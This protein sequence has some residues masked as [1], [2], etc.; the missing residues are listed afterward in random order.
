VDR[1]RYLGE[2]AERYL[3]TVGADAGRHLLA[4]AAL[5]AFGLVWR[6]AAPRL[7]S[8][9]SSRRNWLWWLVA[10]IAVGLALALDRASLFDDAFISFRYA[11]NW[12]DGHGLVFNPGEPVE[13]YTNFLWVVVV[14]AVAAVTGIELPAVGLA[15]SLV[16]FA[17][18]LVVV[19]R[20]ARQLTPTAPVP[21]ATCLLAVQYTFTSFGTTGMETGA[22]SLLV[23]L[24]AL[25]LVSGGGP[26]KAALAGLALVLAAL[27]RPDHAIFYG[28]GGIA[29]VAVAAPANWWRRPGEVARRIAP[30]ALAYA[31][32]L[33]LYAVY[34][35]WKLSFYGSM[36]PNTYFAKS[37]DTP[38]WDQGLLYAAMFFLDSHFWILAI[39]FAVWLASRSPNEGT[40]R[41]RV[42]AGL[43]VPLYTLYVIRVGGDFMHGRFFVS[44]MPLLAL[45]AEQLVWMWR[46]R[47]PGRS[48]QL[49]ALLAF[50]IGGGAFFDGSE[51][52]WYVVDERRYYPL[53]QL[54]PPVVDHA[55]YRAGI[56]L[57]KLEATGVLP[58]IATSGVGMVG[59]YSRLPV[60][61]RV[62]LTDKTVAHQPLAKRGRPGHEKFASLEYLQSRGVV[63]F[64]GGRSPPEIAK[65]NK[66]RFSRGRHWR[67]LRYDRKVM[68]ALR[69]VAP[70]AR[71]VKFERYLDKYIAK[72]EDR[73]P[74]RVARDLR[75]MR[76]YYFDHNDDPERLER[77]EA[78][79][80]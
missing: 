61:D 55:N 52:R 69:R 58:H 32:P 16:C 62:G 7:R 24:G 57:G 66:L 42:F 11:A 35:A 2:V 79:L 40:A 53:T 33:L 80:R 17:A 28:A 18:N 31:A 3:S 71:F 26:S 67:I 37:A 38:Y 44:L 15:L 45:A 65:I 1:T 46:D 59:Y 64:R 34:A 5:L 13:G 30:L 74:D 54:Y 6:A 29:V 25:A 36:L 21:L 4:V 19:T 47:R 41:L 22:A 73:D 68:A 39:L 63:L 56:V 43:A 75:W 50:T 48:W 60:I 20:I 76:A 12:L 78:R 72:L 49:A 10:S 9:A 70:R 27:T 8:I 51:M 77:I 14:G 23:N